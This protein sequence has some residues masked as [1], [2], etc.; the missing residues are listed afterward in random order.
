M[1]T[2][3]ELADIIRSTPWIDT[4]E[5]LVEERRRL[6]GETYLCTNMMDEEETIAAGWPCLLSHLVVDDLVTAGLPASTAIRLRRGELDPAESWTAVAQYFESARNTGYIRSV[7]LTTQRLFS[8]TLSRDTCEEIDDCC[9]ALCKEGYYAYILK[10]IANV[11][12]CQVQS[13]EDDLFCETRSPE[14]FDQDI[15]LTRLTTGTHPRA[16]LMSGI[17]VGNLD[18]Y[19]SVLDWCFSEFGHRAVAVKSQW[20]YLRPLAVGHLDAPP[21]RAFARLRGGTDDLADRRAVEDFLFRR[22]LDLATSYALPVK[23]HVGSLAGA[24][25]PQLSGVFGAV[26]DITPLVQEYRR[27]QFVI[28]HMAW[29]QQEQLLALA[30]HQPN[31][32]VE[33]SWAWMSAPRSAVD[34]VERFLTT[35]PASKLLCFGGDSATIENVVGNAELARR[36]LLAALTSLVTADW[37]TADVAIELVP[38]LMRGNAERIFPNRKPVLEGSA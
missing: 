2:S 22:C 38:A 8:L 14:L 10:E 7:D 31:V 28:F 37:L 5:H 21:R 24:W 26:E 19:V 18:D 25:D 17:D 32:V 15:T 23:L 29:P 35:V 11:D 4:H 6:S 33:M 30:K 20:A 3:T 27:T 16:E 36:G 12:R 13:I 1:T 34:F 9:R